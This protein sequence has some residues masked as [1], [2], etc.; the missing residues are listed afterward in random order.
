VGNAGLRPPCVA[1]TSRNAVWF[2]LWL[3][4]LATDLDTEHGGTDANKRDGPRQVGRVNV[5]G[6]QL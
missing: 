1:S 2:R 5:A 4:G 6:L 3:G